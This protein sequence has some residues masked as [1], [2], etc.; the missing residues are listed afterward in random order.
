M[1]K[2]TGFLLF[3]FPLTPEFIELKYSY[4]VNLQCKVEKA[5]GNDCFLT[6]FVV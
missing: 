5:V 1:N 6:A 3:L 4:I 2:V